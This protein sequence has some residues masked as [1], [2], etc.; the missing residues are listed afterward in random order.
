MRVVRCLK[1]IE[2]WKI[3]GTREFVKG[4]IL[5]PDALLMFL[6]T[7]SCLSVFLRLWLILEITIREFFFC[8]FEVSWDREGGEPLWPVSA[9]TFEQNRNA[10]KCR[11]KEPPDKKI[12][13]Y[14]A[15]LFVAMVAYRYLVPVPQ[16]SK[17]WW[18]MDCCSRSRLVKLRLE[19]LSVP[20]DK[21]TTREVERHRRS[22]DDDDALPVLHESSLMSSQVVVG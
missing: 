11:N 8:A 21:F 1:S 22:H 20:R 10:L 2:K 5:W 14:R 19:N 17:W 12:N 6:P 7:L 3:A 4:S 18:L 16:R 13:S 15:D 9:D